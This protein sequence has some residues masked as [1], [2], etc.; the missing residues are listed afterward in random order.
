MEFAKPRATSRRQAGPAGQQ[1]PP[2]PRLS[3]SL[4]GRRYRKVVSNV[5]EGGVD[6]RQSPGQLQCP[7][8]PP[9]GLH[10]SI[11]GEAVA[12]RPGEDVLFVVRQEQ[13][14]GR[15]NRAHGAPGGALSPPRR[16]GQR[17]WTSGSRMAGGESGPGAGGPFRGPLPRSRPALK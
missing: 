11:R 13:V 7:L 6:P 10:V 2:H 16:L 15:F 12:V 4:S 14:S 3:D 9:R 17:L 5:C 8:L 1:G